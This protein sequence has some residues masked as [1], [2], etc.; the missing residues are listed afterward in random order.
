MSQYSNMFAQ[1]G[2]MEKSPLTTLSMT[3]QPAQPLVVVPAKPLSVQKKINDAVAIRDQFGISEFG[4]EAGKEVARLAS[5][6]VKKT[7][8]GKMGDFGD[9][10]TQIL[11]LTETVNPD[12]LNLEPSK[13]L[14]GKV[15]NFFKAKKVEV[16]AQ[17]ENTQNSIDKIVVDLGKR[18]DQMKADNE[19]LER[20]YAAN[21]KEYHELGESVEAA[22]S[23]LVEMQAQYESLQEQAKKSTDQLFIQSVSEAEQKVK[24]WEKQIDRLKRMQQIALLTAPEIR[25]IQTGNVVLTEKF[26]DLVNT[27]IPA[28]GK[29]LSTTIL[30]MKQKENAALGNAIDDKTN[31]FFRKAAELNAQTAVEVAKASERSVVDTD[32]LVFMQDKLLGSIKEVK[33]IQETGR[34]ERKQASA[35]IDELREQM[36]TE[37]L[38]WSNN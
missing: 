22:S 26:N 15:S 38:S 11:T 33:Q 35:K 9:G 14:F 29:T 4:T 8:T 7:T 2:V 21:L 27:T 1:V 25:Q 20:L 3:P 37:M 24:L 16:V 12:D 31:A 13:G 5:E 6:V 34:E 17:F 36:K 23:M 32:T 28:W 18:Q 30:K 19:F 10:I